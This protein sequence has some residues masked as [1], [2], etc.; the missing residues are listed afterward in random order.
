MPAF[1]TPDDCL[2]QERVASL[3]APLISA[4][5]ILAA[6]SGGPDSMALMHLLALWRR[7]APRPPVLVATVD[8]GLRP[9]AAQEAAFVAGQAAALGFPH[10]TLVWTGPKPATGIQ[11]A[12]R[13]ARYDLL[14]RCAREEGAT[15]LVTAHTL[16]DQAETIL[17]RLSRGS[18]LAGLQGMQPERDRDGI[19]HARP[20]LNWPKR[21]LLGLCAQEKWAFVE[22]PSNENARFARVRWR[23]LMPALAAEG[24]TAERLAGLAERARRVEEALEAKASEVWTRACPVIDNGGVRLDAIPLAQEPFEISLRVLMMALREAGIGLEA[25]RLQRLEACTGRLRAAIDKGEGLRLT[26][27]G[28]LIRLDQGR[29]FVAPEPPRKRGR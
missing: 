22:D 4:R 7:A 3:F 26:V 1:S 19:C 5:G 21:T 29:L 2:S 16:D 12:A 28:A 8:H 15:A 18:G 9:E 24:L 13:E 20:L 10:R 14:V 23:R 27:A 25:S 11:E 17:M 6:V